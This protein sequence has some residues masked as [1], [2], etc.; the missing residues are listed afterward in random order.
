MDERRVG[1]HVETHGWCTS[2][3]KSPLGKEER[4]GYVHGSQ[5]DLET[6]KKANS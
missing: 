2:E 1:W 4:V 5:R 3:G 6:H